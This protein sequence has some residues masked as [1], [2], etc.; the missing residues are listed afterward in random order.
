MNVSVT[1]KN[2]VVR[3]PNWVGDAVM[4][5]AF[6][7][8]IRENMPQ[9]R[10][11]CLCRQTVADIYSARLD[12]DEI[13]TLDESRGRSGLAA[14]RLNARH[15]KRYGFDLAVSL[16][17]SFSAAMIFYLARIPC[18]V[19]YR[20]DWRRMLLT[21][22][23][24]FPVKGQRPHRVEYYLKLLTLITNQPIY[25]RELSLPVAAGIETEFAAVINRQSAES[26]VAIAPGAAQPN[27]MWMPERF[28]QLARQLAGDGLAVVLVGGP[29]EKN[30]AGQIARLSEV[31]NIIDL[32]GA[33]SLQF[34]AEVIRRAAVF[35]GND[36]G[37]AHV[38]AAVAVPAV[39]L[40]G[41]G[42]QHEVGPYSDHA[43]TIA[44]PLF[45]KPCYKNY[46]WRKDKPLE[47]LTLIDVDEVYAA[48]RAKTGKGA[49]A[50]DS[51]RRFG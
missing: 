43:I 46:C 31:E 11:T 21:D 9:S 24:D 19:G 16:P 28:A 30:L 7:A 47:C 42:D 3:A 20:G 32:T 25:V 36:S 15:L 5:T 8:S 10:I 14:A 49:K 29:A 41:P 38:A 1:A 51:R 33:G 13:L 40:S 34:T 35:V 18:R 26:Y 6:F 37:L 45:C 17:N 12:I 4:A 39:V 50:I 44:K 22:S 2:I 48:V 27:K 23:M